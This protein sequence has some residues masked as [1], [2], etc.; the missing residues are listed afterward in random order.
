MEPL[1]AMWRGDVAENVFR[2]SIAVV[3]Q[4]GRLIAA[5]GDPHYLTY[6]RSCAKPLQAA[7]VL[8]KGVGA[9]FHLEQREIAVLCGSH[10]GED[11]HVEA[12]ASILHK[13]GLGEENLLCGVDHSYNAQ[14]REWMLAQGWPKRSIFNNCSGKHS[15]MLALAV[16]EGWDLDTYYQPDHPVQRWIHQRVAAYAGLT[17]AQ[18]LIG[19]DGCGVPVFAMPLSRMALAYSRLLSHHGLTEAQSQAAAAVVAAMAAYPQMVAGT[20]EFCT[21]LNGAGEGRWVGKK[22]SDGVYCFAVQGG[23]ALA[24]KVEDGNMRV[25]P[26]VVMAAL[27]Q[28][29]LLT[30][31]Q[32]QQLASFT[33]WENRNVRGELVGQAQILFQLQ[34]CTA[35]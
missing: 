25:L 29:D 1:V 18:V 4:Q 33:Q 9:T 21:A 15:A 35:R 12:V 32:S 20:G 13:L 3:D 7:A 27:A 26:L 34:P 22:G 17:P 31:A 24:V 6:M 19:V 28:L 16:Q 23:P 11:F 30:P 10:N 2:G 8:E 5:C 14:R